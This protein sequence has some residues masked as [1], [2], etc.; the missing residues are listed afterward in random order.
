MQVVVYHAHEYVSEDEGVESSTYWELL[1]VYTCL[2]GMTCFCDGK[3][4]AFVSGCEEFVWD[5]ESRQSAPRLKLNALAR[6]ICWF[7]LEHRMT[8]NVEWVTRE[9]YTLAD[10]LS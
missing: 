7:D 5:C 3:F 6:E 10:E 2:H 9:E 8:L 4:V 1:G